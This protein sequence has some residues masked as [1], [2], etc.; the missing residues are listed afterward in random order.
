[1]TLQTVRMLHEMGYR[2]SLGVSNISFGL[3][4]R[5]KINAAFFT[6]ALEAGLD[7]AIMNPFSVPMMDAYHAYRVLH[8][9]DIA[10]ADYIAYAQTA[11]TLPTASVTT[12]PTSPPPVTGTTPTND[13]TQ[14]LHQCIVKG[15]KAAAG[16]AAEK[17]VQT[18]APT[19]VIDREMIPALNEVGVAFEEK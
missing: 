10:C 6:A 11:P 4:Q 17:L 16:A 12:S 2:V 8:G 1:I 14:S 19:E 18:M 13:G 7:C 5:D 3:P 9:Y 15:L